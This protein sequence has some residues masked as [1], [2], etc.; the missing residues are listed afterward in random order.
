[1]RPLAA[2]ADHAEADRPEKPVEANDDNVQDA[3]DTPLYLLVKAPSCPVHAEAHDDDREPESWVVM[4]DVGNTAHGNERNVVEYPTNDGVDT[5][6]VDLVH[7][8]LLEIVIAALPAHGVPKNDETEDTKTGGTAP[9]DKGVAKEEVL[10][11][12]GVL[13]CA[14]YILTRINLLSSFHPHMRRPT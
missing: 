6:V 8:G 3:E 7:I 13:D 1:V 10:Y 12:Y 2:R 9:V 14:R 11:D 4:M 5:G